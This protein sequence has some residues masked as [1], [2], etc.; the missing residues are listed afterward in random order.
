MDR[1]CEN[2]GHCSPL[3][4]VPAVDCSN[5]NY[6]EW[7]RKRN[8]PQDEACPDYV[9]LDTLMGRLLRL[10]WAARH[11]SL[12]IKIASGELTGTV[13]DPQI[14]LPPAPRKKRTKK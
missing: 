9:G 12:A 6:I 8:H 13:A 11:L 3:R 5:P 2:C 4:H 14:A 1:I 10:Q 7:N